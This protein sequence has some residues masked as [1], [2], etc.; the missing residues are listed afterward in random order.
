MAGAAERLKALAQQQFQTAALQFVNGLE[1]QLDALKERVLTDMRALKAGEIDLSQIVV[2][3]NDYEVMPK[4]P[5]IA[6]KAG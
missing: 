6:R 4:K 2:T 1:G 5:E 3:D